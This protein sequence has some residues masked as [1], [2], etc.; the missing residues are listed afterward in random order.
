MSK[1]TLLRTADRQ[2]GIAILKILHD[3]SENKVLHSD[4]FRQRNMNYALVIFAGLV[5][6]A[7]RL[8]RELP[9]YIIPTILTTLMVIFTVWD[10]RWHRNKHG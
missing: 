10:R 8:D 2:Q 7:I 9:H 1:M 3:K 5:A 4:M 6:A